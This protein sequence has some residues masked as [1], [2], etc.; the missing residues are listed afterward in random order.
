MKHIFVISLVVMA[1]SFASCNEDATK[2]IKTE[3]LEVAK[4]R[5]SEIKLGGPRFKFDKTEHDFGT[6]N[7]GDVVETVFAFTN[8]GKTELII[9]SAKGSCGC[10]VPQW[11]K[12]PI[13]PGEAGEIKVK[14][15]SYRKPNLQQKQITLRT[16]TE[17]GKEILKIR[18]QVTPSPKMKQ[19]S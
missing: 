13:M 14:F 18:A 4:E 2:K 9:T 19:N 7:E 3:N 6:I 5:D 16:N 12:E 11:P 15:N 10:T 1:L 8:V 17:G